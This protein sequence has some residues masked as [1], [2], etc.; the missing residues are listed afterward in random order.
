MN[1]LYEAII[2]LK[3]ISM[4]QNLIPSQILLKVV[5]LYLIKSPMSSPLRVWQSVGRLGKLDKEE[6]GRL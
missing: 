4:T 6:Y 3:K 5:N 2:S 1:N